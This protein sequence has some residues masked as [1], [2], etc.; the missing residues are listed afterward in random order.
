MYVRVDKWGFFFTKINGGFPIK[1][2]KDSRK[3]QLV[4]IKVNM[5][6]WGKK[7]NTDKGPPTKKI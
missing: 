5:C 2:A 1:K 7:A 3:K 6:P 4:F